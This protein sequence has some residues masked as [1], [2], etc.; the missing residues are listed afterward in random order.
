MEL[1][2]NGKKAVVTGGTRG[3]GRAIV[4][5]LVAEGAHVA[6]CSRDEAS[7]RAAAAELE[8]RGARIH[9]Q[10]LDARDGDALR[11]FI[12]GAV[13][14]LGGL[15]VLV[16]NVSGWGGQDEA[17][18]RTTFEVDLLGAVRCMEV[19]LPALKASGSGSVVFIS[20]TAALEAFGGVRSYNAIKAALLAYGNSLSQAHAADGIRVNSVS[21]G[22]IFHKD[23]PWD[24]AKK[25]DPARYERTL[26]GIP[27]GR[28]GTPE[29]VAAAA[30][31]LAS[32]AAGF[33][34]GT[35]IVVDGGFTRR[36]QF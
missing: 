12:G 27:L 24:K 22:P 11:A 6:L 25:N 4:E 16:H 20:S 30:V 14:A 28:M 26:A 15:D 31:F 36:V 35:N 18:W 7:V 1:G 17:A 10:A 29:E 13:E 33:I 9:A 5:A 19:A 8:G 34:T 2:L 3:I 32:P 23:G 21:P